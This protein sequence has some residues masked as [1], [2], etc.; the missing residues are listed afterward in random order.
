MKTRP[1]HKTPDD[2]EAVFYECFERCDSQVMAALWAD[3]D[4]MCVHPGSA[5]ILGYDAVVRSWA[6][7]LNNAGSPDL[8]YTVVNRIV[9]DDM[10]V[11]MVVEEMKT[12]IDEVALVLA[13]N[14]YRKY[15]SGW[16]MV[17]HHASLIQNPT[18]RR[19]LQ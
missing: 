19:T 2:A 12:A 15:D 4:V 11:H 17:E 6:S 9:S 18:N 13:T 5:L 8:K 10:A 1:V 7:I 14:V 3:G 16:L